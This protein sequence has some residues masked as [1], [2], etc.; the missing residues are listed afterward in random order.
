[1][2]SLRRRRVVMAMSASL[3]VS[4]VGACKPPG[5]RDPDT[6]S[7]GE[8]SQSSDSIEGSYIISYDMATKSKLHARLNDGLPVFR[9][10]G[11]Y[12]EFLDECRYPGKLEYRAT[13]THVEVLSGSSKI[14]LALRAFRR[15]VDAKGS[16]KQKFVATVYSIGE[17]TTNLTAPNKEDLELSG[18]QG[19]THVGN[20][21]LVGAF[22]LSE[23]ATVQ[24]RAGVSVGTLDVG[25]ALEHSLT[26]FA[27]AGKIDHCDRPKEDETS[28][29]LECSSPIYVSLV[30]LEQPTSLSYYF[31]DE[32]IGASSEQVPLTSAELE[33]IANSLKDEV[34]QR[35]AK[36]GMHVNVLN[37]PSPTGI[38]CGILATPTPSTYVLQCKRNDMILLERSGTRNLLS[39]LTPI[40]A[41]ELVEAAD[42]TADVVPSPPVTRVV[43]LV[44]L[45]LS[46]VVNDERTFTTDDIRRSKRYQ[47]AAIY[48]RHFLRH[49]LEMKASIVTFAGPTC[50]SP[51]TIAGRDSWVL[52]DTNVNT[53]LDELQRR[54]KQGPGCT[55][56]VFKH[57]TDITEALRTA[58]SILTEEERGEGTIVILITDGAHSVPPSKSMGEPE[59]EAAKL[60]AAGV[61]FLG[62][63][64]QLNNLSP[65]R[66][67]LASPDGPIIRKRWAAYLGPEGPEIV[68]ADWED[69][70]AEYAAENDMGANLL[71]N[72]SGLE[73]SDFALNI[74]DSED[75]PLLTVHEQLIPQSGGH[76]ILGKANCEYAP[77]PVGATDGS[78]N[79]QVNCGIQIPHDRLLHLKLEKPKCMKEVDFA[80]VFVSGELPLRLE[81]EHDTGTVVEFKAVRAPGDGQLNSPVQFLAEGNVL[82]GVSQCK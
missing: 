67:A 66:K 53:G 8:Q 50:A 26:S 48:L 73:I 35:A 16:K 7:T 76:Q 40:V 54:L 49:D 81:V 23:S 6:T 25:A 18:C 45:S 41:G 70:L 75:S 57:S 46:M 2:P 47:Y 80:K 14:E 19:A 65:L 77:A 37:A 34:K 20:E 30:P 11:E 79:M 52:D 71:N 62:I 68:E 51:I 3:L 33:A 24:G 22:E 15:I 28:L 78:K 58:S 5:P 61:K 59:V 42:P 60:H 72:L 56:S 17:K 29:P 38:N 12:L 44:D 43:F 55:S 63:R 27:S 9:W 82:E 32:V 36:E 13:P 39:H 10:N 4:L 69:W 74:D 64:V 1:M 21:V 31:D